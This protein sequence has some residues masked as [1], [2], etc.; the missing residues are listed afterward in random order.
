MRPGTP[1]FVMMVE[2]CVAV[3]GH[4]YSKENFFATLQAIALEH[5]MGISITNT[6]H[7]TV[8]LIL[9]KLLTEYSE[10]LQSADFDEG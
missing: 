10:L 9:F 2:D 5:C 1:H 3:G 8:P 4:F 7:P 6:E